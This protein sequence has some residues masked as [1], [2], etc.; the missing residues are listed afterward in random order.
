MQGHHPLMPL[1]LSHYDLHVWLFKPNPRGMFQPTNPDVRCGN[2]R[3]TFVE[4]APMLVPPP[5][6]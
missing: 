3:Y 2:Y 4:E 1:D 6:R 5:G